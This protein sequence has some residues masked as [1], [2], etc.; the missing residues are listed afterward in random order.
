MRNKDNTG[1]IVRGKHAITIFLLAF[2]CVCFYVHPPSMERQGT[3]Q[4]RVVLRTFLSYAKSLHHYFRMKHLT[5]LT[6]HF[7][8][9]TH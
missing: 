5:F 9:F 4:R 6:S 7:I 3:D 1:L 2:E 8:L